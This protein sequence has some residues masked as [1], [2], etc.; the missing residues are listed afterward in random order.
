MARIGFI[1]LGSMGLKMATRL[2]DAGHE[3]VVWNRSEGP[4]D[5]LLAK[6]AIRADDPGQALE[7]KESFSMLAND[8]AS[9]AVLTADVF[10]HGQGGFHAN[11]ASV[12][13]ACA[14]RL[15]TLAEEC[16]VN[17]L[18]SPV[19]G[20]PH[21]AEAGKLNILVAGNEEAI[22]A[23]EPY[24]AHLGVRTWRLGPAHQLA[25]LVK[26]A[27]NYNIIHAIQ[28]IAESMALVERHGVE[29]QFFSE[30]L[31]NTLF[32]GIVYSGYSEIIADG[33]Y[34]PQLF[35]LELGKKDL[36]LAIQAAADKGLVF[37]V[38]EVFS[39]LFD[40]ALANPDLRDADW[41]ALAEV[42][43]QQ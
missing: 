26:V 6:G 15:A 34:Q 5:Q 41:A 1:G 42:T 19:L 7:C 12:S 29:P 21:V 20:R 30:L 18:A 35:S 33:S 3:V 27:I 32:G 16:G 37:P 22:F 39:T 4:L 28:A 23:A 17:Y 38:A 43:R 2:I 14:T 9:E 10:R 40:K 13:P 25:N 36:D 31:S 24:F 11:M 8:K